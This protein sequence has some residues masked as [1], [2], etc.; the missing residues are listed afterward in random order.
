MSVKLLRTIFFFAAMIFA[1]MASYAQDAPIVQKKNML[2]NADF[3]DS[4]KGWMVVGKGKNV[5]HPQDPGRAEFGA[6]N[7][8]LEIVITDQGISIWSI[9]LYQEV[10]F[11]K[12]APYV[13]S[14]KAKSDA[15][16]KM[17]SN[18]TQDHTWKNVSGDKS[19]QLNEEIQEFSYQFVMTYDG[20]ALF[21]FC[22]G[23]AGTGH[24]YIKDI[25]IVM[26]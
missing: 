21:Q 13:V 11:K 19:F 26:S 22:L 10:Q 5:Y 15:P 3:S 1:G 6:E 20:A 9:M 2:T 23:L 8:M 24:V 7:G 25:S 16:R 18:I 14:F 12:G 4:L 17:I